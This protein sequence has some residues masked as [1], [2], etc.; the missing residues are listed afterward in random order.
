MWREYKK[1]KSLYRHLKSFWQLLPLSTRE[2]LRTHRAV[3]GLLRRVSDATI[4]SATHDEIYDASYY[5][6]VDGYAKAAAP[7]MAR[8]LVE[9][10]KPRTL[11][12]VGCGSGAFLREVQALGVTCIGIENSEHAIA[13]C[14][15][16]GLDVRHADLRDSKLEFGKHDLATSFEVA[17]HLPES[18]ADAYVRLL[19]SLSAQVAITAAP[20]GQGGI[21]HINEQPQAYWVAKFAAHGFE[22]QPEIGDVLSKRWRAEN[23]AYW[24]ADNLMVFRNTARIPSR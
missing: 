3:A 4:G 16:R 7:V 14:R 23:V 20:P 1:M 24:Y 5:A 17:E 11:V 2:R 19:C 8:G 10:L 18:L 13:T 15:S 22:L 6:F 9:E 12:D 21:N